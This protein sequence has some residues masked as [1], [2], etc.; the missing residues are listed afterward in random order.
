[1]SEHRFNPR[2]IAHRNGEP[3]PPKPGMPAEMLGVKLQGQRMP[4]PH[5]HLVPRES[6]VEQDGKRFLLGEAGA[7][8][9]VPSDQV[10]VF[11]GDPV[12]DALLDFVVGV[13]GV[14]AE[15]AST[16]LTTDGQV[17]GA[18]I[19]L[20]ELARVDYLEFKKRGKAHLAGVKDV[21]GFNEVE[22]T[23]QTPPD[24]TSS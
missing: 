22:G 16:L 10:I 13:V 19:L 3:I 14:Y 23:W 1:V 8:V 17:R 6:V 2:A 11:V 12:D 21:P 7:L 20:F 15:P 18:A 5:V 9:E 24:K 4:K